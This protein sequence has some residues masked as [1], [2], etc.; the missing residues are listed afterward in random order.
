MQNKLNV[1]L[2]HTDLELTSAARDAVQIIIISCVWFG[3]NGT[4][5]SRELHVHKTCLFVVTPHAASSL[6][7]RQ[8]NLSSADL[9]MSRGAVDV[10]CEQG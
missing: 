10:S 5:L 2:K 4:P 9:F 6:Y 7:L 3:A 1:V 8:L